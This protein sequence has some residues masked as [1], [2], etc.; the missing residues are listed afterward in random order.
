MQV[1]ELLKVAQFF[2]EYV[3]RRQLPQEY[4]NLIGAV[5]QAGQ[6][7]APEQVPRRLETLLR[8]HRDAEA[9]VHSPAERHLL[10]QY[11][12][13]ALLG[14]EAERR[15][16]DA[17]EQHKANPQGIEA[18]LRRLK[19]ETTQLVNRVK[20]LTEGL[21]P[22]MNV[23]EPEQDLT[24][25]GR[26]W[27]YFAESESIETIDALQRASD[28]W[29][30]ILLHFAR[31]HG[32]TDTTARIAHIQ[33]ASPLVLELIASAKILVPLA[34]AVSWGI[35]EVGRLVKVRLEAEK[36]KQMK[37][38]TETLQLMLDQAKAEGDTL[39]RQGADRLQQQHN[40]D[41]DARNNVEE[42]LR[43]ILRFIE[44]G[45]SLDVEVKDEDAKKAGEDP[46]AAKA[47]KDIRVAIEAIRTEQKLL[48]APSEENGE[49]GV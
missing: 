14:H 6:N 5:K 21:E 30:K 48:A 27:L 25:K 29:R 31:V 44:G 46:A 15:V 26:L 22:M 3:Q 47:A 38:K 36:L 20:Q 43:R 2:R 7:Q 12:A 37:I 28:D 13:S 35:T 8:I 1:R 32:E 45:G 34:T 41:H 17:F 49:K 9:E 40:Y 16:L 18:S 24:G 33:K 11:G 4:E 19:D 39:A 10:E 42:A 23:V